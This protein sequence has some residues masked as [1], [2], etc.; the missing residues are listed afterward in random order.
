MEIVVEIADDVEMLQYEMGV[1]QRELDR[2]KREYNSLKSDHAD[3]M[4]VLGDT[5]IKL[6]R[7][8]SMLKAVSDE[9]RR[10]TEELYTRL[11]R[12]K[13]GLR[14]ARNLNNTACAPRPAKRQAVATGFSEA[15]Q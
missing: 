15:Q 13:R 7:S 10:D 14:E 2:V 3:V 1:M 4:D 6:L 8:Q 5:S 11:D 12:A 9:A